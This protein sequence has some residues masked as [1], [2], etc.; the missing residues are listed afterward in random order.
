MQ[1]VLKIIPWVVLIITLI[2]YSAVLIPPEKFWAAGLLGYGILPLMLINLILFV[3]LSFLR[4]KSL[5]LPLTG[6]IT[7]ILFF[8]I[9]LQFNFYSPESN[10]TK[11]IELLSYNVGSFDMARYSSPSTIEWIVNDPAEIKCIQ[12]FYNDS[13][14][15]ELNV[16]ERMISKG[17]SSHIFLPN[18]NY[19]QSGLAIFTRYPVIH[20]GTLI[21]NEQ[22]ANNCI[23]VDVQVLKDTIRI[24]NVHLASMRIPLSSYINP[25]NYDGKIKSLIRKLKNGGIRRSHEID[26]IIRHTES[27]DYP[28]IICGDFNDIPYSYNYLK[29]RN[30]FTNSF[31]E[32]GS[33]YGFS[34][35]RKLFFLRIDHHFVSDGIEPIRYWVDR[36]INGSDHF[37]TRGLYQ[38][39]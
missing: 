28:F 25:D 19:Q 15:P 4:K 8:N 30:H 21:L 14:R 33:G 23:Y 11:P 18:Q 6:I 36:S 22:S 29:L 27:C 35:N 1:K 16:M 7:G 13:R 34:F 10:Q 38:I 37:P 3:F 39:R 12:E 31:E 24:Y 26:L 32:S 5:V 9:T 2:C 17:F 20:K